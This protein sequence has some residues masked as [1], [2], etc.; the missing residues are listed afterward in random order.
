[1]QPKPDAAKVKQFVGQGYLTD[2]HYSCA[3]VGVFV[4]LLMSDAWFGS[5]IQSDDIDQA[6]MIAIGAGI[7]QLWLMRKRS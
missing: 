3:I 5:G 6:V 2:N 4:G 1:M 7:I